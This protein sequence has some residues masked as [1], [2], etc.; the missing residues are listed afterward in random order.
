MRPRPYRRSSR[1]A[2]RYCLIGFR[3]A[4][5]ASDGSF[6]KIEVKVNRK[7]LTVRSR[8]GFYARDAADA[9]AAPRSPSAP[10]TE[11]IAGVVPE[12]GIPLGVTVAPFAV[13]GSPLAAVAVVLGVDTGTGTTA[14][15]PGARAGT[16][17]A[18]L[19]ATDR[20]QVLTGIFDRIGRPAG[21]LRKTIQ[22][23]WPAGRHGYGDVI[24]R[25]DVPPGSYEVRIAAQSETSS[26]TGSVYT[27]V[28][29]PAFG[30][31]ALSLSGAVVTVRDSATASPPMG[32]L[33][34]VLPAVPTTRRTFTP[35]EHIALIVRAYRGSASGASSEPVR[36]RARIE[37]AD[38]HRVSDESGTL[39]AAL[40]LADQS[41]DYAYPVPIATL[42]PGPYVLN[43]EASLGKS[44]VE[45]RV[46]FEIQPAGQ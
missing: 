20:M 8:Q 12:S 33:A 38:G 5:P 15:A 35:D 36:L 37:D 16:A 40:F 28:D 23:T 19:V 7:G 32:R 14:A 30:H 45:R 21:S 11:A 44:T 13:P 4:D 46:R 27:W 24:T 25:L 42:T 41:A 18:S 34:G 22:F 29:V 39:N 31:D 10:L 3:S 43:L 17:T 2:P 1:K 26:R 9:E 6:H